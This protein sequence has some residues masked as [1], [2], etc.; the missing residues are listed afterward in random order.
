MC[1]E[2]ENRLALALERAQKTPKTFPSSFRKVC[3]KSNLP[4]LIH[5][6]L[7][8]D[9]Y[10]TLLQQNSDLEQMRNWFVSLSLVNKCSYDRANQSHT[11]RTL[12]KS[13]ARDN[14]HY[15]EETIARTLNTPG[16]R[17]YI[18][19]SSQLF[20]N[21]L[22]I[23]KVKQLKDVKIGADINYRRNNYSSGATPLIYFIYQKSL[24]KVSLLLE[25][26]ANINHYCS[27]DPISASIQVLHLPIFR[28]LMEHK[29]ED[30]D[31]Y[32]PL[33]YAM[34]QYT[35]ITTSP[36]PS[37]RK[38][39]N[40]K[41]IIVALLDAGADATEGLEYAIEQEYF[42]SFLVEICI[43]YKADPNG[44]FVKLTQY[45]LFNPKACLDHVKTI[46]ALLKK[47]PL[48][49]KRKNRKLLYT[50][51]EQMHMLQRWIS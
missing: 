40:C 25:L 16:A 28:L 45:M 23:E 4:I 22:T 27:L 31:L 11:V 50:K 29:P 7:Y 32:Y 20:N 10:H 2:K 17:R 24:S 6:M 41:S 18:K 48:F 9:I 3:L 38:Q 42:D 13:I 51:I 35:Q 39:K 49:K 19:T 14:D 36:S 12:I 15:T 46:T 47:S 44:A 33:R 21:N 30:F 34:Q 1:M 37:K 26:K 43:E 5:C 8:T